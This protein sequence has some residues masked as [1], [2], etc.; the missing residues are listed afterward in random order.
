MK[1][2]IKI[3][4]A[5]SVLVIGV[6]AS[7][8]AQK[9]APKKAPAAKAAGNAS[10]FIKLKSGLEYKVVKH[11][12]GKIKPVLN[13]HIEMY[14]HVHAGDS[15]IYDSRKQAGAKPIPYQIIAPKFKGDVAEGFMM[16]VAGDSTVFKLPVDSLK[17]AGGQLP[18]WL[19]SGMKIEYD[20]V[21]VSVVSEA[22]QKAA[23][24]KLIQEYMK[25]NN[26]TGKKTASG[27]Y[28]AISKEGSGD[29]IKAGQTVSVNY[30][31][32]LLNGTP[33]DTNMDSSFH[34]NEP[35]SFEIGKGRVIKGWDEGLQLLKNGSKGTLLIPSG[36]AYGP[37]EKGIIPANS[38]LVFDVEVVD[39]KTAEQLKKDAEQK[40]AMIKLNDD[41]K[42]KDYF[43]KNNL[44][45]VKTSSGLYYLITK[46]GTGDN[47]KAGDK[48]SMNYIGKFMDGRIFDKNVDSNFVGTSPL[49]FPLGEHRVIEGWDEGISYLNKG[50]RATFF[51]PSSVAY[52]ERGNQGIP[53]NTILV[54]DVELTNIE[55]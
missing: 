46:Q 23:D 21:M 39:I 24:D 32:K 33:F 1:R 54:F 47:A 50:S 28:Y 13:D 51:L 41:K 25:Q 7:A 5:S 15:I 49:T 22:A 53:P 35:Y 27:L 48:V 11:G 3:A 44:H 16:M 34:H 55:H 8:I 29:L 6:G 42:L 36:L 14:I 30:R 45:P 2:S 20:V 31:G 4:L 43:E 40:S 37:Q 12:T 9:T 18:P 10:G 26:I 38:V 52:G 17:K 19:T